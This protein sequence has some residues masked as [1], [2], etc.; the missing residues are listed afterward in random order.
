MASDEKKE[1]Q[2]IQL[3]SYYDCAK[4]H[5]PYETFPPRISCFL[6]NHFDSIM[7]C[8]RNSDD[9]KYLEYQCLEN[10]I[11]F[12]EEFKIFKIDDETIP[13]WMIEDCPD[14][15]AEIPD[16]YAAYKDVTNWYTIG[17]KCTDGYSFEPQH[18][19]VLI[20]DEK[21]YHNMMN[22]YPEYDDVLLID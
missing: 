9:Y 2:V 19:W 21:I 14:L 3:K 15:I 13:K 11:K 5:L 20:R 1:R 4:F 16:E 6:G 17:M 7:Y 12:D 10:K 22:A 8:V 18:E